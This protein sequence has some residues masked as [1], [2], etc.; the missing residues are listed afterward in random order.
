MGMR[1]HY[2]LTGSVSARA[3]ALSLCMM[4]IMQVLAS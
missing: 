4:L 3:Y 1:I 2:C